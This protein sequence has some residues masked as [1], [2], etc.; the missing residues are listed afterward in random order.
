M[1][2]RMLQGYVD[3]VAPYVLAMA[4]TQHDND[5]WK[6]R[7]QH[8]YYFETINLPRKKKKRRRKELNI[9]WQIANSNPMPQY[10]YDDMFKTL[11]GI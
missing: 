2:K 1:M 7:I 11:F 6:K 5:E 9:D 3:M 4:K 10:D 8:E